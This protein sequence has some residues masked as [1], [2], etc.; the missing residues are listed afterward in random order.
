MADVRTIVTSASESSV[1]I[2]W[3][4][5]YSLSSPPY[6]PA[7]LRWLSDSHMLGARLKSTARIDRK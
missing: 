7:T 2:R 1:P 5:G 4:L 3:A 6:Q